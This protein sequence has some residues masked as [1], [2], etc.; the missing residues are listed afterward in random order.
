MQQPTV[1][2]SSL[3]AGAFASVVIVGAVERSVLGGIL[4]DNEAA[5]TATTQDPDTTNNAAHSTTTIIY[6][7]CQVENSNRRRS[8]EIETEDDS[9]R[10]TL[11]LCDANGHDVSSPFIVVRALSLTD[12]NSGAPISF[13]SDGR[14][15]PD[16]RFRFESSLGVT[17]GYV[18]RIK[19]ENLSGTY[20]LILR[21]GNDPTLHAIQFTAIRERKR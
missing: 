19:S 13:R 6:N 20:R 17:G 2:W 1:G 21:A 5:V 10:I 15:N 8:S 11:M 16:N 3:A 9:V 7:I 12:V 4:L 18:F 14:D